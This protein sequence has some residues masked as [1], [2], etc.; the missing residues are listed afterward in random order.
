MWIIYLNV[1]SL[2]LNVVWIINL[3]V[4]SSTVEGLRKLAFKMRVA[5]I[6]DSGG[7]I[8][9]QFLYHIYIFISA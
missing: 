4:Q 7:Y 5:D 1:Q 3:N 2:I 6:E 8:S 9:R